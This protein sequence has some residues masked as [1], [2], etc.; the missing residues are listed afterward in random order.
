MIYTFNIII[1]VTEKS[2]RLKIQ[3]IAMILFIIAIIIEMI[4]SQYYMLVL[5]APLFY[6]FISYRNLKSKLVHLQNCQ[7]VTTFTAD[8]VIV[9]INPPVNDWLG[10]YW[11]AYESFDTIKISDDGEAKF[12]FNNILDVCANK[13]IKKKTL[14]L[15]FIDSDGERFRNIFQQYIDIYLKNRS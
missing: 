2:K 6:L 14:E 11:I 5:L 13:S 10:D 4:Y 9:S 3:I 12:I 1:K 7:L 15:R 8:H